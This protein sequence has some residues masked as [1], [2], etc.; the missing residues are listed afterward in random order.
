MS[1]LIRQRI[2]LDA[3]GPTIHG[4]WAGDPIWLRTEH[5][6]AF[7]EYMVRDLIE[8][9]LALIE[10]SQPAARNE[11]MLSLSQTMLLRCDA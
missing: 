3:E 4:Q 8:I 11:G 2:D 5:W 9:C 10:P 7:W 6:T 1:P